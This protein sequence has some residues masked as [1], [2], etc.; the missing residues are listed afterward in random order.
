MNMEIVYIDQI[1]FNLAS[2]PFGFA[3]MYYGYRGYKLME[4]GLSAYKY[5]FFVVVGLGAA[6]LFDLLRI[7]GYFEGMEYFFELILVAVAFFM[8][9]SFRSLCEFVCRGI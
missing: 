4:G 9:F 6:M 3:A 1:I 7:L 5:F 8:L 2:A